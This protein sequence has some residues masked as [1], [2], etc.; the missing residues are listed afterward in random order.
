MSF[1]WPDLF[2]ELRDVARQMM[3]WKVLGTLARTSREECKRCAG[4]YPRLPPALQNYW[5]TPRLLKGRA[6]GTRE[7]HA[8]RNALGYLLRSLTDVAPLLVSSARLSIRGG[9]RVSLFWRLPVVG[10][11]FGKRTLV[12]ACKN[13]T[14][15]TQ[16]A[17]FDI[18]QRT[19]GRLLR[20]RLGHVNLVGVHDLAWLFESALDLRELL[21]Q[22]V[23]HVPVEL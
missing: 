14:K 12:I 20:Y 17:A 18:Y 11:G 22:A 21:M 2:P 9:P 3:P 8:M 15:S 10:P 1:P 5:D 16:K 19:A 23:S 4:R 13:P 7:A 6:L